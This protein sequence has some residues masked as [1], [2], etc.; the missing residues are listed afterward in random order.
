MR[1]FREAV[2]RG[3]RRFREGVQAGRKERQVRRGSCSDHYSKV[4]EGL[5]GCDVTL[6]A[7]KLDNALDECLGTFPK[8]VHCC[9]LTRVRDQFVLLRRS[10]GASSSV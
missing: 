9:C 8:L 4:H 5:A 2:R 3:R 1:W 10:G 7:V 6:G